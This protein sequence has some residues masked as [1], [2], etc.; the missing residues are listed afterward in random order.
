[1]S[2]AFAG[3][4]AA[5]VCGLALLAWR[6]RRR[7]APP[8][9]TALCMDF[10]TPRRARLEIRIDHPAAVP[11]WSIRRIEWLAP[12]GVRIAARPDDPTAARAMET[13]L[14]P[15]DQQGRWF[16]S[17]P[18]IWALYPQDSVP[19]HEVKL[20][21]TLERPGGRRRRLVVSA[22]YPAM[23][24]RARSEAARP[25]TPPRRAPHPVLDRPL[26]PTHAEAA[27]P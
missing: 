25:A 2:P 20:R 18:T 1:V 12:D 27:A 7:M 6:N 24:W 11:D 4:A 17:D 23:D 9:L 15:R 10:A 8:E 5:A 21:L 16:S 14:A 22:V 26:A 13:R 3:L 19:V